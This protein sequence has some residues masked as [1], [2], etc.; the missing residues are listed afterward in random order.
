MQNL[1]VAIVADWLTDRGGAE[2]VVLAMCEMFP[3]AD[4][5][6]SV[7]RAEAF[8]EL[9]HRNVTTSYLQ[10]WPLKFKHTF[11]AWARPQAFESFNLDKYDLVLS[12]ASAEAKGIITKPETLHVCYCHTPTRY[13]WSHYQQYLRQTFYGTLDPVIKLF[14][15]RMVHNLRIWD[16]LAADRVDRFIANSETTRR[17]IQKYYEAESVVINPPVDTLRFAGEITEGDYYLVVGRQ[18]PYKKTD[19]VIEAFNRLGKKLVVIGT[20]PEEDKLKSL[21]SSDQ[22][23]MLGNLTDDETTAY[24]KGARALIFPQEEDFGIV[25]LEA[26][27]AGKPV[28]AYRAGGATE[29]VVDNRTGVFFDHQTVESLSAAVEQFETLHFDPAVC[30]ARAEEFS[31]DNFKTNLR[32]F[33]ET[34]LH[35]YASHRSGHEGTADRHD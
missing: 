25:P 5:Y 6:T 1:K 21:V 16:R 2:R 17:R 33:I 35:D 30:R 28:I 3:E 4:I 14:V 8:P 24:F 12:S 27:A 23:Q 11:Y 32:Q 26:M 15:P 10:N 18:V 31:L 9:E 34:A 20:G 22:I 19:L 29:T 13:Y 7:F